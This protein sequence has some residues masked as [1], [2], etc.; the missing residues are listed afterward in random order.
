MLSKLFGLGRKNALQVELR[1]QE[2]E[3]GQF[4]IDKEWLRVKALQR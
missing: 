1:D 2:G 3:Q 4:D